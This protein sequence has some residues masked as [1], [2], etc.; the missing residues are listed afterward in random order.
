MEIRKTRREELERVMEIYRAARAFMVENGNPDQW[1]EGYPP[2]DLIRADIEEGKSYVCTEGEE[3][4]GVFYYTEGI[5]PTYV[6]IDDGVWL[7]DAP[8]GVIH[9]LAVAVHGRGVAKRCFDFGLSQCGNIKIDTHECNLPMQKALA[10]NGFTRCGTI[11]IDN[12]DSRIA[13]Q[14]SEQNV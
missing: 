1:W 14:K 11:Y 6:R 2:R 10:K 13:Y 3:I 7:N 5:D 9:R 8:Y 4:L 12:G